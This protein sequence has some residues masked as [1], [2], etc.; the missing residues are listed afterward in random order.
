MAFVC[1]QI[2]VLVVASITLDNNNDVLTDLAIFLPL[3]FTTYL[4]LPV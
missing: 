2:A 3:Y 1:K 4:S